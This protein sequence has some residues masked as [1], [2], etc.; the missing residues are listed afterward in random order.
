MT[1]KITT[2]PVYSASSSIS[3]PLTDA[4]TTT[5]TY[6]EQN[7]TLFNAKV[8]DAMSRGQINVIASTDNESKDYI[9]SGTINFDFSLGS[10][11]CCIFLIF[12]I[13]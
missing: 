11:I 6:V 1:S 8:T 3:T 4:A 12:N 7:N 9:N 13:L 2:V 5:G 10:N